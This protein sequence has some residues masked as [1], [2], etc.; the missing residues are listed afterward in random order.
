M[1]ECIAGLMHMLELT[2]SSPSFFDSSQNLAFLL[3]CLGFDS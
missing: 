2:I 3:Q 1:R